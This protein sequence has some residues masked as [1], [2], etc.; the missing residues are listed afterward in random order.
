MHSF[1]LIQS[2]LF[3]S[4]SSLLKHRNNGS[5]ISLL[6]CSISASGSRYDDYGANNQIQHRRSLLVSFISFYDKQMPGA[7]LNAIFLCRQGNNHLDAETWSLVTDCVPSGYC[8]A[9]GTCQPKRCRKDIVSIL[10]TCSCAIFT[11]WIVPL[12]I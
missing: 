5:F 10:T 8:T 3:L 9:E 4:T 2:S 11:D 7:E 1:Q 12:R 6:G